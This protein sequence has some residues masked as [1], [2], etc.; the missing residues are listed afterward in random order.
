MLYRS[1][2][3]WN[4][5][6][7]KLGVKPGV[8][9]HWSPIFENVIGE[10]T[11]S[12]GTDDIAPFIAQIVHES[13]H[14]EHMEENLN[15]SAHRLCAV[16]PKRFPSIEAAQPYAHNPEKLANFVYGGRMG[17]SERGDGWKFRGRG[18]LQV[19]GK[20][21]YRTVG[22]ALGINLLAD[23]DKLLQYEW[24]LRASIAWWEGNIPDSALEN[25][26]TVTKLVNGGTNGLG[27][28]IALTKIARETLG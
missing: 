24:S 16:W 25:T 9:R 23:P 10:N 1:E 27:E 4:D 6:L 8:A 14:M 26:E 17:N 11:F 7:V 15:Y 2:L 18:L 20:N 13:G 5:Y 21:N 12:A 22:D 28:R 19:T 3:D